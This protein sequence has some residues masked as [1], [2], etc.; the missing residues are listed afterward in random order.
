M[1]SASIAGWRVTRLSGLR[2]S[3]NSYFSF[4]PHLAA[5]VF[6]P[7]EIGKPKRE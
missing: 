1:I 3:S 4:S 5:T 7:A 2:G 6:T